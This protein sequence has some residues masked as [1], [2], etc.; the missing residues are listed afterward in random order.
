MNTPS[1]EQQ[2]I[3]N[4]LKKGGNVIVDA[5]AGSGKSTTILSS[6]LALPDTPFL[7]ITYNKTL[8]HEVQDKVNELKIKNLIVHT[9]HSLAY[10]Y[11][12]HDGQMD[13]GIRRI[14]RENVPPIHELPKCSIIVIDE[15]QDMTKLYYLLLLKFIRDSGVTF[16]ILIMGDKMQGIYDFKGSDIRFLTLG[17]ECWQC[18]PKLLQ[19]QFTHCT[20]NTSYRITIPMAK[21]VN[22]VLLNEN[23]LLA[24]KEG[25]PVC[26]FRRDHYAIVKIVVAQIEYILTIGGTYDEI[27]ILS[28]SIKGKLIKVLENMLVEKNIPCYLSTMENQDQLDKRIIQNKVVFSTFHSVKGRQR[29]YVFVIGFDDSY[30]KFYARTLP[31]DKC[32]NT[33]YVGTTRAL[34]RLYVFEKCGHETDQPL[35][36]L[37]MSHSTMMKPEIDYIQFHGASM[38]LK[39]IEPEN[40]LKKQYRHNISITDLIK[41]LS[42]TTMDIISP[43]IDRVFIKLDSNTLQPL[44][45]QKT[46]IVFDEIE[47]QGIKETKSGHFEDVSDINGIVLPMLFYDYLQKGQQNCILQKL[48]KL[49]MVDVPAEKHKFLHFMVENMPSQCDSISDYLFLANLCN[50]VQE[51]LYSKLKQIGPHEYDWLDETVVN[52]CIQQLDKVVGNQCRTQSWCAETSIITQSSDI[53]HHFIDQ[54]VSNLMP[55]ENI[56]YRIA[57]RVDLMTEDSIW[58]WKCTSNLTID[59]KIQLILYMWIWKMS[60][61]PSESETNH[62]NGYLFNIKTG[63]LLQL[64]AAMDDLN[65]IVSEIIRDKNKNTVVKTDDEFLHMILQDQKEFLLQKKDE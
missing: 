47:I 55:N 56:L 35:S 60:L 44:E 31:K 36:F 65:I 37:K 8:R 11:Y 29:K 18:H 4:I 7:Q 17:Q 32:P 45:D 63:E 39:I 15:A 54:F 12:H 16:Q 53:E 59:H 34:D 38:G 27:Y 13:N 2:N 58:E 42:E 61:N 43:I 14:I 6:A 3:I 25:A 23:R 62:K 51:K 19:K 28:G 46:D 50:S 41:F 57:A 48:V 24:V 21:F 1:D 40:P 30:F 49:A 10:N 33:L 22:N 5:C 64:N 9:Y 52:Q 26:Y 20:L